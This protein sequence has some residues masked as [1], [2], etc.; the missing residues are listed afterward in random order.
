MVGGSSTTPPL[1][2]LGVGHKVRLFGVTQGRLNVG[3]PKPLADGLQADAAVHKFL[4]VA[5]TQVMERAVDARAGGV[6]RPTLPCSLVGE[7]NAA[8]SPSSE[9][10]PVRVA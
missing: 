1:S 6:P 2:D 9:E 10:R 3:V 5:V 4:R 7:R 8:T